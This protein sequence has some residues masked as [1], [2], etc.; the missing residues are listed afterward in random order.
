VMDCYQQ[1]TFPINIDKS[2][3]HI[4]GVANW[5]GMY[6]QMFPAGDT[7]IFTITTKGYI[8]IAY[9]SL[10]AGSHHAPIEFLSITLE[11]RSWI[12]NCWLGVQW[13]AQDGILTAVGESP[14]IMIEHCLFGKLLTR[15][16]IRIEGASTRTIIRYN[17][18]REVALVGIHVV[19]INT[20][21]GA[22]IG[23]R[24]SLPPQAGTGAAIDIAA[25]SV[26]CLI[27]DNHAM[28]GKI[29]TTNV[30]YRDLGG[31]NWGLNWR[32]VTVCPPT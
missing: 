22:I 1:E 27:D 28:E 8:E 23:N 24:F 13:P 12:H 4:L 20:D 31:C 10:G 19:A 25:G 21:L 17:I 6:T 3:V 9:F 11:A 16:G 7:A 29:I 26:G 15:D 30:P 5:G 2:R 32:H 18:F 14:E